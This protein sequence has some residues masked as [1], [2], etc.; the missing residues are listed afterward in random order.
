M[1]KNQDMFPLQIHVDSI[2]SLDSK[3]YVDRLL[4][5]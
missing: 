5:T 1:R 2:M 3:F 4:S